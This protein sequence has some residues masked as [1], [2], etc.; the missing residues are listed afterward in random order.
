[1]LAYVF[2][3]FFYVFFYFTHFSWASLKADSLYFHAFIPEKENKP[4]HGVGREGEEE[5]QNTMKPSKQILMNIAK[6]QQKKQSHKF[7]D[8]FSRLAPK[9]AK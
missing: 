9:H 1:M 7:C 8:S 4:E 2:I 5:N 6:N 3:Q